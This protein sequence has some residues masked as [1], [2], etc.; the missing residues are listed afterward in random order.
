M[1]SVGNFDRT[2]VSGCAPVSRCARQKAKKWIAV[3]IIAVLAAANIVQFFI[4]RKPAHICSEK[5]LV[6]TMCSSLDEQ[7]KILS[8]LIAAKTLMTEFPATE[9]RN[10]SSFYS[11]SESYLQEKSEGFKYQLDLAE[12]LDYVSKRASDGTIKYI[13]AVNWLDDYADMGLYSGMHADDFDPAHYEQLMGFLGDIKS[14]GNRRYSFSDILEYIQAE[15]D[16]GTA[17]EVY[18]D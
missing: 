8:Y 10:T 9:E 13:D 15:I 16:N 17:P 6:S 2:D 14:A 7:C 12:E 11:W 3:V 1:N 4:Y 18:V 5:A